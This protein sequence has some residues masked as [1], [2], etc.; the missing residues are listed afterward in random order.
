MNYSESHSEEHYQANI[1]TSLGQLLKKIRLNLNCS[2]LDVALNAGMSIRHYQNI[3]YGHVKCRID[4]LEKILATLNCNFF[5]FYEQLIFELFK[6]G[7]SIELK[8]YLIPDS[9]ILIRFADDID[10]SNE[11]LISNKTLQKV[12][13]YRDLQNEF[14]PLVSAEDI[15]GKLQPEVTAHY[16][17]SD[18]DHSLAG[19]VFVKKH[20]GT[21]QKILPTEIIILPFQKLNN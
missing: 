17:Y 3:E 9:Y 6:N 4:T 16:L 12:L 1:S 14:I 15:I 20:K 18:S 11:H 10:I 8:K 2:Q 19:R 5:G 21:D 7:N 13:K